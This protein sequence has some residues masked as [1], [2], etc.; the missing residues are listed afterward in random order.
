MRDHALALLTALLLDAAFGDQENFPHP[1]RWMG[2]CYAWGDQFFRKASWRG[3][4]TGLFTVLFIGGGLC[5]SSLVFPQL[6]SGRLASPAGRGV[7]VLL[8]PVG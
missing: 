7:L 1:V 4:G 2:A 3:Y 5:P 6:G 8:V